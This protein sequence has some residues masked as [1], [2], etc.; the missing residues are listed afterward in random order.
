MMNKRILLLITL[1]IIIS[2]YSFGQM[3]RVKANPDAPVDEIFLAPTLISTSTVSTLSKGDLNYTVK[4]NFGLINGGIETFYGLDQGAAVRLGFQYG[5]SDTWMIGLG[6][7]NIQDLVDLNTTY[8]LLRQKKNGSIP[9]DIA[10]KG[11]IGIV[12]EEIRTYQEDINDRLNYFTSIMIARKFNNGLSLQASPMFAH[13]NTVVIEEE[14]ATKDNYYFALGLNAHY[15]AT[16]ML[17]FSAEYVPILSERATGTFNPLGLSIEFD[18]GGHVFQVYVTSG[19][20][21]IE[22]QLISETT[23]DFLAG[24][25]QIGFTINRVFSLY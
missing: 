16:E 13:F 9:V 4:H 1:C 3:K 11:S 6:R 18:T 10:F 5:L 25:F 14:N 15:K 2:D 8:R 12:T 21:F 7:T 20:T 23:N 24:E 17:S 19:N 22:Q